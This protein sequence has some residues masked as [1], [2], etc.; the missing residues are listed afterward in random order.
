MPS[1]I[2]RHLA[3]ATAVLAVGAAGALA[4]THSLDL[5][6]LPI[7]ASYYLAKARSFG[8]TGALRVPWGTG[9]DA[10]FFP[11]LSILQALPVRA[12]G[13][14]A[15][16]I[17][18]ALASLVACCVLTAALAR[19][20]GAGT[21]GGAAAAIAFAVDPLVGKWAPIP[22]AEMP[23]LAITLGALLLASSAVASSRRTL[24]ET[25]AAFALGVAGSMRLEALVAAPVLLLLALSG[26]A[27]RPAALAALRTAALAAAPLALHLLVLSAHGVG[28][29]RLHYVAELAANFDTDR[30]ARNLELFARELL[31]AVPPKRNVLAEMPAPLATAQTVAR[32]AVAV[33]AALGLAVALLR[34]PRAPWALALGALL[35]Y[36]VVHALWHYGDARFLLLVWPILAIL[37]GRGAEALLAAARLPF[38]PGTLRTLLAALASIAL[39]AVA[40]T[41]LATGARVAEAHAR[42]WEAATG[43]SA[44]DLARRIDETVG[45]DAEG[46][47][48]S[49]GPMVAVHRRAPARFAFP[50]PNFFESDLDPAEIPALLRSGDRFVLTGLPFGEWLRAR[51]PSATNAP[52][53]RAVIEEP[54]RTVI[55]A[56]R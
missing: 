42:E 56:R 55:V 54:G 13:L 34:G 31:H 6:T 4:L 53:Y 5:G 43:G 52:R 45:P 46:L 32:P 12:L 24:L 51:V 14:Q 3:A 40:G 30:Y 11:G 26:R 33:L 7:D 1:E 15:G 9:I 23:A 37:A 19:R 17:T 49:G 29:S 39:L 20:L 48:E 35:L 41:L 50:I 25:A 8:E 27:A 28:P 16:W 47:Y 18:V 10:K 2:A 22:Y 36:P 44:A 38:V 21:V